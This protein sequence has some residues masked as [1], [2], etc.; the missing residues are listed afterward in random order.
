MTHACWCLTDWLMLADWMLFNLGDGWLCWLLLDDLCLVVDWLLVYWRMTDWWLAIDHWRL[1]INDLWLNDD[2]WEANYA[3][4]TKKSERW[5]MNVACWM[6]NDARRMLIAEWWRM[7][8]DWECLSYLKPKWWGWM[9]TWTMNCD[10]DDWLNPGWWLVRGESDWRLFWWIV[11]D[12]LVMTCGLWFNFDAWWLSIGDLWLMMNHEW[13]LASIACWML[14]DARWLLN[15]VSN[16]AWWAVHG[17][18]CVIN[19]AWCMISG[20]CRMLHDARWLIDDWGLSVGNWQLVVC[21]WWLV[22]DDMN[23]ERCIVNVAWWMRNGERSA[24]FVV[25]SWCKMKMTD[26]RCMLNDDWSR[27]FDELLMNGARC[28]VYTLRIIR[29]AIGSWWLLHHD[30]GFLL[31]FYWWWSVNDEMRMVHF[32][33]LLI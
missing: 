19:D 9:M 2:W 30:G 29:L 13:R 12:F 8:E 1:M 32:E 23:D 26:E 7:S 18:L 10:I 28:S 6:L 27:L 24:A 5:V 3:W 33:C 14:I 15:D 11:N 4:W 20:E 17:L 22:A 16:E 21:F 25:F 31:V